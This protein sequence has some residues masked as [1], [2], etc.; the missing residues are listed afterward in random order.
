MARKAIIPE[1][2]TEKTCFCTMKTPQSWKEEEAEKE[3]A[4][5][6]E[7]AEEQEEEAEAI[8]FLRGN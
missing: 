1:P 8:H 3:E 2:W 7:E 4:T 6:E 5:E